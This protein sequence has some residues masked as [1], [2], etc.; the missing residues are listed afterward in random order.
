MLFQKELLQNTE[1]GAQQQERVACMHNPVAMQSP[2]RRLCAAETG[3]EWRK[4]RGL[5]GGACYGKEMAAEEG[6]IL[7]LILIICALLPKHP[8]AAGGLSMR[9]GG[10][11]QGTLSRAAHWELGQRRQQQQDQRRWLAAPLAAAAAAAASPA[12][13]RA[14][15]RSAAQQQQEEKEETRRWTRGEAWPQSRG[16]L[17]IGC[18]A[19]GRQ[20]RPRPRPSAQGSQLAAAAGC[21]PAAT[22][23]GQASGPG[24]KARARKGLAWGEGNI[25]LAAAAEG[26]K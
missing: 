24:R 22:G 13:A 14:R 4:D 2:N 6:G 11:W 7:I 26:P 25:A 5:G 10:G 12:E 19:A 9:F 8:Q 21:C 1:S 23:E 15:A 18:H 20:L 3:E 16:R 17:P